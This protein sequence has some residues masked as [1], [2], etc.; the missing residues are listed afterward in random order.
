[1]QPRILGIIPARYA[2]TRFPGKPLVDIGGKSM[3]QRVVEQCRKATRLTDVVVATDDDRIAAHLTALGI[4]YVMTAPDHPS[5][6]D[7]CHEAY[8]RWCEQSGLRADFVINIQGDE[9]FIAPETI[10]TLAD[11]C[12]AGTEL[13]TLVKELKEEQD[14][15]STNTAKVVTSADGHALYFS[16]SPIPHLRGHEPAT[17]LSKQVY[18]KHIGIYAYQVEVLA[19]ITKLTPSKL[20]LAESLEQLRWLEYGYRIRVGVTTSDSHG[21]DTPED[22]KRVGERFGL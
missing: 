21:I 3:I 10:N 14:L 1:M 2:S 5:G 15:F 4:S 11:L 22:V 16:R 17:W 20:E 6:T 7:R 12:V 9:P 19:A 8:L 13:A 18:Y